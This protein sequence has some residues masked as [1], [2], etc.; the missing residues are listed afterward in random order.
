MLWLADPEFLAQW[1]HAL[2]VL[3]PSKNALAA[4]P[5]GARRILAGG[6]S[7]SAMAFPEDEIANS[8]GSIFLKAARGVLVDGADP[9]A[10]AADAAS[11]KGSS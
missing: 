2:G 3:P 10:A 6:I 8:V 1:T 5:A 4:W 9:G 7:G 11:G